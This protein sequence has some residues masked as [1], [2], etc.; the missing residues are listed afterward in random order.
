[1]GYSPSQLNP[2]IQSQ[3]ASGPEASF[4]L[5]ME[6][7][8]EASFAQH[9]DST[10]DANFEAEVISGNR[11]GEATGAGT[12]AIDSKII[13]INGKNYLEILVKTSSGKG[14]TYP[15][16]NDPDI[17]PDQRSYA[18]KF[19]EWARSSV[20]IDGQPSPP[21]AGD[22]VT[23][24]YEKGSQRNSNFDG[25]RYQTSG[26]SAAMLQNLQMGGG[27]GN[28]YVGPLTPMAIANLGAENGKLDPAT[29]NATVAMFKRTFAKLENHVWDDRYNMIGVRDRTGGPGKYSDFE[30]VCMNMAYGL[31]QGPKNGP[32]RWDVFKW[33]ATTK[34]G[35]KFL[36][37]KNQRPG[38]D[39]G[40]LAIMQEGQWKGSHKIRCHKCGK[41]R[42]KIQTGHT[43]M[44]AGRTGYFRDSDGD[45]QYSYVNATKGSIGLNIHKT[46]Q[47]KPGDGSPN[48][49]KK[50]AKF[51]N[52]ASLGCQI[53]SK[54]S[55][56]MDFISLNATQAGPS[57][58]GPPDKWKPN[59]P[60]GYK[61]GE[62]SMTYTLLRADE[63]G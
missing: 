33:N 2:K 58:K 22:I 40:R 55:E 48:R 8:K 28:P 18:L 3:I 13:T 61:T 32:D 36:T 34:P 57:F 53:F 26:I 4:H 29:A 1:M 42:K 25:L 21:N 31:Q 16:P 24:F 5:T 17:S 37:A 9:F 43:A 10:K 19:C 35:A 7:M 41:Y 20:P 46:G 56:F 54:H 50:R 30:Y 45:G 23:C 11:T 60:S 14:A 44:G 59:Y 15:H 49:E 6:S 47:G 12:D 63:L 39:P 52:A 38:G 51:N 62:R 27:G